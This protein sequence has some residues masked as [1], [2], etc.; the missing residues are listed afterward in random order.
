MIGNLA[1]CSKQ[2]EN[3]AVQET[4]LRTRRIPARLA[5]ADHMHRFIAG[6]R[7]PSS[8]GARNYVP[9]MTDFV[10][11]RPICLHWQFY[12]SNKRTEGFCGEKHIMRAAQRAINVIEPVCLRKPLDG[13]T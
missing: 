12:A 10:R 7:T 1:R 8:G 11:R 9:A 13:G 6:D 5:F 3:E 4:N 2:I